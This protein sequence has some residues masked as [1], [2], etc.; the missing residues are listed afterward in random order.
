[1]EELLQLVL[2]AYSP[3]ASIDVDELDATRDDYR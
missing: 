2:L 1:M 3:M